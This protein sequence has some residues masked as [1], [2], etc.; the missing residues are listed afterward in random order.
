MRNHTMW[1][2]LGHGPVLRQLEKSFGEGRQAHSYLIVGP[3][4]VGKRTLAITMAQAVNC[5]SQENAPCG[6]CTQCQRIAAHQHADV[7]VIG[8]RTDAEGGSSRTEIGI[9][10]VREL[11]HQ[12][13]LKPYEGTC[14]VFIFDGAER[15]SEEASNALLKTLEEPPPQVMMILVASDDEFLLP[16]IRSR[17]RR[18]E[19][20]PLS[21][22]ELARELVGTRSVTER[23]A[24]RL[25]R[26]SL[27]RPGRALDALDDPSAMEER[28]QEVER[29]AHLHE[30]TLE[31]RFA[32]ASELASSFSKDRESG[33][34]VLYLWLRWWRDL[35][36]FKEGTEAYIH[37]VDW[38][39]ELRHRS[40]TYTTGDVVNFI[41]AILT[42]LEALDQNA[43][44]RLALENLM[45]SFP[46]RGVRA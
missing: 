12:A 1:Q 42:T 15:M 35:L 26:L 28:R 32:Y 27:G 3:A 9:G 2:L 18:L 31:E 46:G 38:E 14:R 21:V 23:E 40:S 37:N 16:T 29:I 6:Q 24:E 20:R 39:D 36:L 43:N 19:L 44:W 25:A 41:K 34:D 22:A 45:L 11:Q 13:S 17:C 8:V 10:D 5:L 4:Q 7:L 33:R 30:A